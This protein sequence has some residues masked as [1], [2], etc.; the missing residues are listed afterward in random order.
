MATDKIQQNK[1][2]KAFARYIHVSPQKLRLV[3]DLIRLNPVD[4]ALEQ[5]RFSSKNAALPLTKVINSAVANA[6][7]NFSMVRDNLYVKQLMV[8]E[9]IKLKR[10][11]AK[12]F[13]RAALIQKKTSHIIVVLDERI[14]GLRKEKTVSKKKETEANDTVVENKIRESKKQAHG[15]TRQGRPEIKREIGSRGNI[16][17][18]LGKKLFQRKAI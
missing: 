13:G 5:L 11:R 6:E 2:V 17:G 4:V 10:F 1:D 16:L 15:D 8:N 3:A 18:N 12:G 7:N 9:G 14:S